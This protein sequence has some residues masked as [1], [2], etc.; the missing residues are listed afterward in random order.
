MTLINQQWIL[1]SP[2]PAS[3][4]VKLDQDDTGTCCTEEQTHFDK[5]NLLPS[6]ELSKMEHG[7]AVMVEV[8][9]I[10]TCTMPPPLD[11]SLYSIC[12][13]C[14]TSN[15]IIS[16]FKFAMQKN[17]NIHSRLFFRYF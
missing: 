13:K 17:V 8:E 3:P 15:E 2:S 7:K 16:S 12:A 5:M 11:S 1:P 9:R 4:F 14:V 10:D 6:M